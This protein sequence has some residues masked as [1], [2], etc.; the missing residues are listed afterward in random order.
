LLRKALTYLKMNAAPR[1]SR[2]VYP[3]S[4]PRRGSHACR[5]RLREAAAEPF[6][7]FFSGPSGNLENVL[8]NSGLP[9]SG[10]AI[11][12][13]TNITQAVLDISS[14]SALQ[15]PP[16][17]GHDGFGGLSG[18][19]GDAAFAPH[20]ADDIAGFTALGSIE[21]LQFSLTADADGQI[22][23]TAQ[24]TN[25][26]DV[27]SQT[28]DIS[29]NG[30]NWFRI[31]AAP[32]YSLGQITI[33]T[34]LN[35]QDAALINTLGHIRVDGAGANPTVQQFPPTAQDVPTATPLHAPEPASLAVWAALAIVGCGAAR[36][37]RG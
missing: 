17:I 25:P 11:Q 23:L 34:Q 6:V 13:H 4:R 33:Q 7:T 26:G 27:L 22:V 30:Q 19:F 12:G 10:T 24:G 9:T 5:S 37:R 18:S 29:A 20:T 14:T 28:F 15:V 35:G 36:W 8:F 3:F 21:A 16:G 32:G 2:Y 1:I 31:V